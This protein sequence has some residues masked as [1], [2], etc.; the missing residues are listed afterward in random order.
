MEE[1]KSNLGLND[2]TPPN[3]QANTAWV[4]IRNSFNWSKVEILNLICYDCLQANYID[5]N[6]LLKSPADTAKPSDRTLQYPT[7]STSEHEV[8][9]ISLIATSTEV[10]PAA[11]A[12]QVPPIPMSTEAPPIAEASLVSPIPTPIQHQPRMLNPQILDIF[13]GWTSDAIASLAALA[14]AALPAQ[15]AHA[16]LADTADTKAAG[17]LGALKL[18]LKATDNEI[19]NIWECDPCMDIHGFI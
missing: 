19:T 17:V 2:A 13:A 9:P 11:E 8:A 5:P 3:P 12:Q 16:A 6:P 7:P 14:L 15:S 4:F 10:P 18:K 1:A